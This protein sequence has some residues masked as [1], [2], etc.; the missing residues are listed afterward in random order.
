MNTYCNPLNLHY[1]Y[2]H[3]G[4]GAHREAADPTLIYYKERYY[5]FAS[6]SGGFYYS[7]DMIHWKYHK[8]RNLELYHYAPDAREINGKLVFCASCRKENGL[9][10]R[11]EDPLSDEFERIE[12]QFEFWD[13]NL[14]QDEDGRVYFY[15]GC[16]CGKPLYG[17][18]LDPDT[19]QTI[20]E[21]HNLIFGMPD[22]HGFERREYPGA[23]VNNL[24]F[25]MKLYFWLM[26][27]SGQ[28]GPN[29]PYIEGA[30]MNKWN[31]QYYFQYAAPATEHDT[32]GDGVYLAETP[33]GPFTYQQ[34]NP[35]SYKPGGFITAAGHGSTIEDQYGN[36]WHASTMHISSNTNFERR[37]GLFPAG[38]D[39]KGILFC[40]QNFA[41][42]PLEI[43]KGKFE[44]MAI[45]P[46]WMLLSYNKP[47]TTS[48]VWKDYR[49]EY[50]VDE[51]IKTS[52]CAEGCENEWVIIDLKTKCEV[53]AI[54][55]NIS[56][57]EVPLLKVDKSEKSSIETN[58]RYIDQSENLK[59]AWILEGSIDGNAWRTLCDKS[60]GEEDLSNDYI[61][62]DDTKQIQYVRLTFKKLPYHKRAAI[63]GLRVFGTSTKT[64]PKKV[65][66]IT[67]HKCDDMTAELSWEKSK[68]AIGYNVRYGISPEQMYSSHMVYGT[69]QVLLTALNK[70]KSYYVAVD[71][72]GEG[73]ITTGNAQRME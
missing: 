51:N 54:Q 40:N 65:E 50:A 13:P 53:H 17:V 42:Y 61:E 49:P 15:W 14:F 18:E 21:V 10:L 2:Q 55:I 12:G 34:H 59:T 24:S 38:I 20:G 73:G 1:Q 52:W 67:I 58:N 35:F 27:I 68:D 36:L 39:A 29:D 64:A 25:T 71:A 62:F 31:G 8:N 9:F 69:E 70:G 43:P 28:G 7:D 6:M 26:K 47:V 11:T 16:N 3:Y 45:Q 23:P 5:L 66:S 44:P 48:S 32:Y 22:E 72:F 57:V 46:K 41:D 63:S 60:A 37:V 4:R 19:L 56:D 33:F 30:F